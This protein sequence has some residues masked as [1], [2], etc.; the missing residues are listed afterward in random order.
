MGIYPTSTEG[1]VIVDEDAV[2][3]FVGFYENL[4]GYR[5]SRM[6]AQ[7]HLWSEP[8]RAYVNVV[9]GLHFFLF[10]HHVKSTTWIQNLPSQDTASG[11]L[12]FSSSGI[13]QERIGQPSIWNGMKS[14]MI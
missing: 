9:L 13:F 2:K 4:L 8:A 6:L 5:V 1:S 3:L 11:W 10:L 14:G 12:I 7:I